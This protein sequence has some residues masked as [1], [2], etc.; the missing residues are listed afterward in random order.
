MKL[1]I[2]VAAALVT[3]VVP[4]A[5]VAQEIVIEDVHGRVLNGRSIVLVDWDGFIANPAIKLFVRAPATV[6]FPA[7]A[8]LSSSQPRLYFD[9]PSQFGANGPSKTVSVPDALTAVPFYLSIF[10]DRDGANET[11]SL[12]ITIQHLT[13]TLDV[14]VLDQDL[15]LPPPFHVTV[16]FSRDQTGF[17]SDAQKRALFQQAVAD[18]TY[19]IGDMALD[20]VPAGSEMTF[21][22]NPD[23]FNSGSFVTNAQPYTGFLM[24]AYG[25]SG[26]ELR[27]GGEPSLHAFQSSNGTTLPL[28]RSGGVEIETKGNFNTL[29]WFLTTSESD[30]WKATNLA[31][32]Q[33]DLYSIAHHEI[34][35]SLFFNPGYTRF[36]RSG[37][38]SSSDLLAYHGSALAISGFDH[39]DDAVDDSSRK[40]AFGNEYFGDVP[41]GRW[42]PTKL[43]LLALAAVGYELRNL[44]P[45]QKPAITASVDAQAAAQTPFS[46]TLQAT[47]GVPAYDWTIDAGSLPPGLSLDRFTG[48]ISG[49]PTASGTFAFTVR[50]RDS[51]FQR[52]T[53]TAPASITV[54]LP[55]PVVTAHAMAATTITISW[56]AIAGAAKYEVW[57]S[58]NGTTFASRGETTATTF[59]DAASADTAYLY[60]VRGIAANGTAGALSAPELAVAVVYTDQPI[61][62]GVTKLKAAHIEEL[63]RA[64]NAV[65]ILSG[66]GPTSFSGG[67]LTGGAIVRASH[68][69]ELRAS[70]EAARSALTLPPSTF[71]H[72]SPAAGAPIRALDIQQ[73][74]DGAR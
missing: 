13:L 40:G 66:L 32:E 67:T 61:A 52:N 70:L 10:P 16:D 37:T 55:A 68:V 12:T 64:V 56:P 33:N 5:A 31:H 15:N 73:L 35:H 19:F 22:W 14:Q 65:R 27:S 29:G 25:I 3:A 43:D 7:S 20:S 57:R 46:A 71:T 74:R 28:R 42:L 11:H 41:R 6:A 38:L 1:A 8:V 21:I 17:F 54:L 4:A 45:L 47:G 50:V 72:P 24:Y 58:S 2:V 59:A 26:P 69:A 30:W 53:A 63:R 39:F 60:K 44:S 18:W 9:L 34:G 48:V 62:A 49:T 36:T 23:G 51:D